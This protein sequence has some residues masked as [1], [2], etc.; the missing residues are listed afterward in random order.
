MDKIK[1]LSEEIELYLKEHNYETEGSIY[2]A[3]MIEDFYCWRTGITK[4]SKFKS[5]ADLKKE[6]L[7]YLG[8]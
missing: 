5:K 2:I 3:E 8:S 1:K 7:Q 6:L 4:S